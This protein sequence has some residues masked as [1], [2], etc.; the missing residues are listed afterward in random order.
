MCIWLGEAKIRHFG[1][2]A[3]LI[4]FTLESWFLPCLVIKYKIRLH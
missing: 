2:V 3:Q 1:D 4:M